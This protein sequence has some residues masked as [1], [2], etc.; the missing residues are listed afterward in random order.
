[1][2]VYSEEG[3]EECAFHKKKKKIVG[4]NQSSLISFVQALESLRNVCF[5][6]FHQINL[7]PYTG[8]PHKLVKFHFIIL[9]A[10]EIT[11]YYFGC[12]TCYIFK[13]MFSVLQ[14]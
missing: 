14:A 12:T 8:H 3:E 10:I 13:S 7:N 6:Q 5:G 1:M 11:Q 9:L 4:T 2:N